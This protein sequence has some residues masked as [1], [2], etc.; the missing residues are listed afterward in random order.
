M[1]LGKVLGTVVA[2]RKY[3]GL[4]GSKFLIVQPLD[5][6]RRSAGEPLVAVDVVRAG[7]GDFVYLTS[8]REAAM[9]LDVFPTPVDA[10][11]IGIVDEVDARP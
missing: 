1:F 4:E 8:S 9:A 7:V 2:E 5:H 11:I 10:A 3:Q 6:Q